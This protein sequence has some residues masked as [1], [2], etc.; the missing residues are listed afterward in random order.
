MTDI[1]VFGSVFDPPTRG[2]LD[3][4]EQAAGHFDHIILV[5]SAAHA[6]NK[7]PL[8]FEQ[9]LAL[10]RCFVESVALPACT[11]EVSEI[12]NGLLSQRPEKPVYTFDV[13]VVLEALHPDASLGFIRGPDNATPKTWQKFYRYAEIEARWALFTADQRVTVRSSQV[14]QLLKE[15]APD[16]SRSLELDSLV[17][18]EIRDQILVHGLYRTSCQ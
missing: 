4:L 12:E 18:P 1:G 11:L 5:P 16:H 8:S 13:L 7:Q 10:L 9:R 14:R 15:M 3:V 17:T 2:H 6:F